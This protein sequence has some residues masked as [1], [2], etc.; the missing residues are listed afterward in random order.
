MIIINKQLF[1]YQN[2]FLAI[3]IKPLVFK[4]FFNADS[5][6]EASEYYLGI[7]SVALIVPVKISRT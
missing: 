4:L 6:A 1:N 7:T 5:F 3:S 2:M